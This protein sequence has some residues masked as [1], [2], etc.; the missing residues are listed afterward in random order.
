MAQQ[1]LTAIQPK[2]FVPRTTDSRHGQRVCPNLLLTE[3]YPKA[4]NKIWVSDITYIALVEG[5]WVYLGTWMD[6]ILA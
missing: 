5:Q 6:Y 2:S 4:P 3:P 1:G